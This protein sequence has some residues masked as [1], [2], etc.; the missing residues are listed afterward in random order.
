MCAMIWME[1]FLLL[2]LPNKVLMLLKLLNY[3]T[4]PINKNCQSIR[5]TIFL[6]TYIY[7]FLSKYLC[8][9]NNTY[10]GHKQLKSKVG[11]TPLNGWFH[12]FVTFFK[13]YI[14]IS[15]FFLFFNF[16]ICISARIYI[17]L[18]D[19]EE[20]GKKIVRRCKN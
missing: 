2:N 16:E 11:E 13:I 19:E 9:T 6:R 18:Q 5:I 10:I 15:L 4:F 3:V 14:F 12:I 8:R 17:F 7:C 1:K 20:L